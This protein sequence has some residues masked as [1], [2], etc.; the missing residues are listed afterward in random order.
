MPSHRPPRG[1]QLRRRRAEVRGRRRGQWREELLAGLILLTGFQVAGRLP[2]GGAD[3]RQ[4]LDM[5][6]YVVGSVVFTVAFVLVL[7]PMYLR[8]EKLRQAQ[9]APRPRWQYLMFAA[10]WMAMGGGL[11]AV[12]L[13]LGLSRPDPGW[14][15][16]ACVATGV[17][18]AVFGLGM[19]GRAVCWGRVRALFWWYRPLWIP[20]AGATWLTP[21]P[22]PA[23]RR[24]SRPVDAA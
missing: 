9:A 4:V 17:W 20:D 12:G 8:A 16:R 1:P 3:G 6:R 2:A 15:A 18:I 24:P 7:I 22:A 11:I 5:A 19:L 13:L 21:P 23:L 10:G 14:P